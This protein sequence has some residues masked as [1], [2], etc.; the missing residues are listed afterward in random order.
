MNE[1][2]SVWILKNC[3]NQKK[4]KDCSYT[5]PH[6]EAKNLL[7]D[8]RKILIYFCSFTLLKI[9]PVKGTLYKVKQFVGECKFVSIIE[10]GKYLLKSSVLG[11]YGD[12]SWDYHL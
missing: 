6:L 5:V 10:K 12:Y 2:V 3:C 11:N 7:H 8:V 9:K 1:F 4:G